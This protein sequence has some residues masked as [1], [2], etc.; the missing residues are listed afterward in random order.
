M[1][2]S[3][4]I[5][6]RDSYHRNR[7]SRKTRRTVAGFAVLIA[8]IVLVIGGA[9]IY[10]RYLSNRPVPGTSDVA[11]NTTDSSTEPVTES[12]SDTEPV[13]E[14]P[15]D[16]PTTAY[17]YENDPEERA[18]WVSAFGMLNVRE[19]PNAEAEQIGRFTYHTQVRVLGPV[20][21]GF[22]EV[23]G[24][25]SRSGEDIT[26][27][28]SAEFITQEEPE[29][30]YVMFDV[31]TFRQGDVRWSGV[32]LGRS[33]YTIGS[34]GCT[35]CCIA[36]LRSYV[37]KTIIR[38]DKVCASL[39]YSET[40]NL[41]WPSDLQTHETVGYLNVILKELRRGYPMM[42]GAKSR[43]GNQHWVLVVG[44]VGN[45]TNLKAADFIIND[46]GKDKRDNLKQFIDD[47]PRL[48]K[49]ASYAGN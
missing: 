28:A 46:P 48:Y 29:D 22:Y 41:A 27:Y 4:L 34:A 38:P 12:P 45:G 42:I 2:Y 30:P 9:H 32:R 24:P 15:T 21:D 16:P 44:Y 20:R 19:A 35:T 18:G 23:T 40:G 25:D 13:T 11:E 8:L 26:G 49:M 36:M 33:R 17:S 47:Y 1:D 10:N 37:K 31:P 39:S 43:D 5:Q 6:N 7:R 3:D 14:A